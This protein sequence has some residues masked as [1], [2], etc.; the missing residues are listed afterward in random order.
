MK[1]SFL[2]AYMY[3]VPHVWQRPG[4]L[5]VICYRLTNMFQIIVKLDSFF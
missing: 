4:I 3:M 5:I 2:I 1:H